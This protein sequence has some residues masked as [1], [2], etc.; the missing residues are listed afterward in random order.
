MR[1]ALA[2]LLVCA[3][4]LGCGLPHVEIDRLHGVY[5]THFDGIPD[6]GRIC[7]WIANRSA[8]PVEWVRL[9]LHSRNAS[10]GRWRTHW[11]YRGPLEPG[12]SVAVE[13]R[14]PPVADEI[15]LR[16]QRSGRGRV[17]GSGRPAVPVA[18]CSERALVAAIGR[19]DPTREARGRGF[20]SM[21]GSGLRE[22]R[23]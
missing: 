20:V 15:R 16:V 4:A 22:P 3:F 8:T 17:R 11:L 18:E 5:S 6:Q 14:Q 12:A 19:D 13:L 10:G 1:T 23:E 7:A 9:R 21:L 2:P